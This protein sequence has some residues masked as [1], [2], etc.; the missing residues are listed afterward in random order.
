MPNKL[1]L[2]YDFS[3][4]PFS[5]GDIL[6]FHEMSLCLCKERGYNEID[7]VFTYDPKNPVQKVSA[8]SHINSSNFGGYLLSLTPVANA[9]PLVKSVRV[10]RHDELHGLKKDGY[11]VWP[12]KIGGEYMFYPIMEHVLNHY[13]KYGDVPKMSCSDELKEW[14]QEFGGDYISI[15]IRRNPHNSKRDSRY[16]AWHD[17]MKSLPD[18]RFVILCERSEMDDR[19]RLPNVIFSKDHKTSVLE[20]LALVQC[21]RVHMG[22]TSGPCVMAMFSDKPYALYNSQGGQD[23]AAGFFYEGTKGR[24]PYSRADQWTRTDKETPELLIRDFE[25]MQC[26]V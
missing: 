7:F 9:N 8:F 21:S 19:L 24:F 10:M 5:V 25:E 14:A 3:S 6:S 18:E 15:Q 4:Q 17:F 26:L 22:A 1:M 13:K 20:D 2:V 11:D 12:P 16:M 23:K